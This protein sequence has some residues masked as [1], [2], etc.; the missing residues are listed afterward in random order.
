MSPEILAWYAHLRR[1]G[2]GAAFALRVARKRAAEG[3]V[4][5]PRLVP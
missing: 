2:W 3:R 4:P 5:P 1:W